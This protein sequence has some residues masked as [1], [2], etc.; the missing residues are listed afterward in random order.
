MADY[1]NPFL[2]QLG[3]AANLRQRML[4][5]Q[6]EDEQM[7]FNRAQTLRQ[8]S[9]QDRA[10]NNAD[11]MSM[12][13]LQK[14]ARPVDEAGNVTQS[15]ATP[16]A[17]FGVGG[18]LSVDAKRKADP[19]RMATYQAIA[20]GK[21]R[22][23]ELKTE[24]ELQRE[25]DARMYAQKMLEA[26]I[27]MRELRTKYGLEADKE[28]SVYNAK[29]QTDAQF[30]PVIE[31]AKTKAKLAAEQQSVEL[32]RVHELPPEVAVRFSLPPRTKVTAQE[33]D[34]YVTKAAQMTSQENMAKGHD[35]TSLR[36]GQ[37]QLQ[38]S[39]PQVSG[40]TT[41]ADY[42]SQLETVSPGYAA[43]VKGIIEGRVAP[44]TSANRSREAQQLLT[45]VM[46]ADPAWSFER[47]QVRKAFA[48]G[49]DANNIQAINT[50][51]VHLARMEDAADELN[52]GSFTPAN[53][54]FNAVAA[55]FG[56]AAQPT[57]EFVKTAVTGE[58]ANALKGN[59]TDQEIAYLQRSIQS[60]NSPAAM[61][62]VVREGMQIL[63]D[64]ADGY[65]SR[66]RTIMPN[67]NWSPIDQRAKQQLQLRGIVANH[68][69]TGIGAGRVLDRDTATRFLQQAG[70][71][72]NRARELA[73]QAG[74]VVQ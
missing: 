58:M 55:K 46:R 22:D 42:L 9:M 71:D 63:K 49:K 37:M 14:V 11:I 12:I 3:M 24:Q 72:K 68:A 73:R 65:E 7:Q 64:K 15:M 62:R 18:T 2:Q 4:D 5:R 59:A 29:Q 45:D 40:T 38:S 25:A 54:F 8:N 1:L 19:G 70:G 50:G 34:N 32:G 23:Y 69:P 6:R 36:R 35:L 10:A 61:K 53:T 27:A 51:I 21:S 43:K 66:W 41:G 16:A 74:W 30:A 31:G 13:Q 67:D 57:F 52:N 60:S 44:P 20:S 17:A 47:A 33:R 28:L 39:A 56:N 48:T 26:Q